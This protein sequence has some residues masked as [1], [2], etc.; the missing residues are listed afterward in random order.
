MLRGTGHSGG[1]LRC[2]LLAAAFDSEKDQTHCAGGN[3]QNHNHCDDDGGHDF[4]SDS[5]LRTCTCGEG[6]VLR[7]VHDPAH[8]HARLGIG[9]QQVGQQPAALPAAARTA[10]LP[11]P[12]AHLARTRLRRLRLQGAGRAIDR[13]GLIGFSLSTMRAT[14]WNPGRS[15]QRAIH[16]TM[17]V[18]SLGMCIGS[19]GDEAAGEA[20][21]DLVCFPFVRT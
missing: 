9:T 4:L 20:H 19:D 11:H 5:Q 10:L 21:N 17:F 18:T 8:E 2:A 16:N 3:D 6:T 7:V 12:A 13:P 15:R 1:D 14:S